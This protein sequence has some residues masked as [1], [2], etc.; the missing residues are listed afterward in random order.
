MTAFLITTVCAFFGYLLLTA[1]SGYLF[2]W[3]KE[4]L[5]IKA[6]FAVIVGVVIEGKFVKTSSSMLNLKRWVL[7]IASVVEHS[8]G[9][10]RE[11]IL[12]LRAG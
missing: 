3:S 12:M 11:Q 5:T 1:A 10:W 9:Q 8:V 7:F 4:E 6:I 2:L